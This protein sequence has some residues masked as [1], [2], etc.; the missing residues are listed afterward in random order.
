MMGEYMHALFPVTV[1]MLFLRA[2]NILLSRRFQTGY[3][4]GS[5]SVP[6]GHLDGGETIIQA[7]IRESQEETGTTISPQDI[8]FATVIHRFEDEE[9]IDFFVWVKQWDKEPTNTEPHKC[10]DL[11]WFP[12]TNLPAN[13]IPYVDQGLKTA[14]QG[15]PFS[16][17]GWTF[18]S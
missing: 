15:I 13:L 17:F 16:E 11:R 6:A 5:Y 14:L 2:N 18:Q 3:M 9:R 8:S 10:D 7:V 1:H 12:L 4:D